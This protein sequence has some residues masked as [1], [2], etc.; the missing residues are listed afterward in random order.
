MENSVI[1]M[2]LLGAVVGG[3]YGLMIALR[4]KKNGKK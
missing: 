4:Q 3:L 1:G 2:T